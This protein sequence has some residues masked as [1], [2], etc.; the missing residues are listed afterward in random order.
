MAAYN[1]WPSGSTGARETPEETRA[2]MCRQAAIQEK[3]APTSR[4]FAS[5][6]TRDTDENKLQFDG[7]LSHEVLTRYCEYMHKNRKLAD[8]SLRAADNWKK[9]IPR[10]VYLSSMFRHFMAVW[11]SHDTDGKASEEELCALLFNVSGYLYELL[12]GR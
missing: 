10:A 1:N 2:R 11:T 3:V 4:V 12:K 5:G 6:A 9:S 8:G 7:F